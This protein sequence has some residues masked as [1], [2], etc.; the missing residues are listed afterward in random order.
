MRVDLWPFTI[1]ALKF[2]NNRSIQNSLNNHV[3]LIEICLDSDL[4]T[5]DQDAKLSYI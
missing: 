3:L 2:P 1:V 4:N 5:A